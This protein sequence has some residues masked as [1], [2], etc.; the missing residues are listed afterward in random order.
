MAFPAPVLAGTA[1]FVIL[2]LVLC[3]CGCA[4][5]KSNPFGQRLSWDE[6]NI[7][8]V[9]VTIAMACM[10]VMWLSTWLHQW[11]PLIEPELVKGGE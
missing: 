9:L 7:C 1:T 11:K 2:G 6:V 5:R 10:W 3:M 8:L 4:M